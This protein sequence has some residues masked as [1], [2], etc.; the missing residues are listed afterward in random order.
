[1][2]HVL[3]PFMVLALYGG[4][5]KIDPSYLRDYSGVQRRLPA[6]LRQRIR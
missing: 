3:L 6:R 1:M 4:M 5:R 2:I